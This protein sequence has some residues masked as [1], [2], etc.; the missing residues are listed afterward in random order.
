MYVLGS[1]RTPR[2]NSVLYAFRIRAAPGTAVAGC[3]RRGGPDTNETG[4]IIQ[5][6]FTSVY[7][8]LH[9]Y[10]SSATFHQPFLSLDLEGFYSMTVCPPHQAFHPP[11]LVDT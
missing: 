1:T 6:Y 4:N 8:I 3:D 9:L 10:L 7:Q 5:G 2:E 11:I